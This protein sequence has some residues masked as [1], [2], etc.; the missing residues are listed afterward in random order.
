MIGSLLE[1][2]NGLIRRFAD[3]IA[4]IKILVILFSSINDKK[5][6]FEEKVL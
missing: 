5:N 2:F 1:Q 6:N 3:S 4:R